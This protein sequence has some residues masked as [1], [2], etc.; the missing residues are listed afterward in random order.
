MKVHA[1]RATRRGWIAP[2][3]VVVAS[4]SLLAGCA[5]G[6]GP[7]AP[8]NTVV[9]GQYPD[10]YPSDYQDLVDAAEA[11]GGELTIYSNTD[12]ENWAPIFRD[13]QKKYPFVKTINANNL[14][15]DEVFQRVL[16][17]QATG[18]TDADVL[19][20]NAAQAWAEYAGNDGALLEYESP[21]AGELPDFAQ[22]LP[23]VYAMSMDPAGITY[24]SSLLPDG[25]KGYEDLASQVSA[26]TAKFQD[27]ITTRDVTGAFGFTVT[28]ALTEARPDL[29]SAFETIL[30]V[31][32]P[33]TSSGTQGEKILAGEYLAGFQISTAPS[34]PIVDSSGGL[35]QVV[36]PE[37]GTV[38]LPR[39]IGIVPEATHEATAKL[40]LDF[41]L[42][43]EGQNAVAEGGLT[44]YRDSVEVA[45]GRHTYQEVVDTVG[46][47][48][49]ILG[50]YELVPEDQVNEFVDRWNGLLGQ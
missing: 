33:E 27:K 49:I 36:L 3:G 8:E 37:D 48:Q 42:S 35:Y 44:S 31:A 26:D 9:E 25:I 15:S 50:T 7:T 1:A 6:S 45:E 24:N 46:E 14:D 21:E 2:L 18:S 11:E 17:E 39:G 5:G 16:S 34:Y 12:Q 19:V 28:R 20:S 13:F 30:P 29:W 43:E 38:V 23:N 47:D 41:V 4:V 22:V 32:R 10:Y 40:F